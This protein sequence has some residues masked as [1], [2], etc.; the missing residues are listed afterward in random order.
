MYVT[1]IS[2]SYN[3]SIGSPTMFVR[4]GGLVTECGILE[5]K[6]VSRSKWSYSENILLARP[7]IHYRFIEM[8]SA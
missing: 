6:D 7:G 1:G 2:F 5:I 8:A 3:M 4:N